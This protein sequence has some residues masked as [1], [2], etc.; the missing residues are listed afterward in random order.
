MPKCLESLGICTWFNSE[1][2]ET[3]NLGKVTWTMDRTYFPPP[4]ELSQSLTEFLPSNASH[5]YTHGISTVIFRFY[6]S[7]TVV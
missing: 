6:D 4:L 5:P 3:P 2:H 7:L 1:P